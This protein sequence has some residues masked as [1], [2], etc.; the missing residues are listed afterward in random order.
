LL[1]ESGVCRTSLLELA[2]IEACSTSGRCV[3]PNENTRFYTTHKKSQRSL[4][5]KAN[6]VGAHQFVRR[7]DD[8]AEAV[9]AVKE[10]EVIK[11]AVPHIPGPSVVDPYVK[12]GRIT[13]EYRLPLLNAFAVIEIGGSQFKVTRDDVIYPNKLAGI[14]VNDIIA[15][16]RVLLVGDVETTVVGRPHIPGAKVLAAVES[17]FKDAKVTVFKK[18][19]GTNSQRHQG[20]RQQLTALRILDIQGVEGISSSPLPF[21]APTAPTQDEPP[22]S[23]DA[24][25]AV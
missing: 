8:D 1:A 14:D 4:N 12:V 24:A 23:P 10:V 25:T 18:K 22:Q 13:D 11:T 7:R 9:A 15:L 2:G 17:Q 3:A 16:Q 5:N 20:H 6:W 21:L 19:P